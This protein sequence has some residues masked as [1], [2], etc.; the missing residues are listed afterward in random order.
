MTRPSSTKS[1][2]P[3]ITQRGASYRVS[4]M[5]G[6]VRKT[7]TAPTLGDAER[8]RDTLSREIDV[9]HHPEKKAWTLTEGFDH[10]RRAVLGPRSTQPQTVALYEKQMGMVVRLLGGDPALDDMDTRHALDLGALMLDSGWSAGTRKNCVIL[11]LAVMRHAKKMGRMT[12]DLPDFA[13]IR[14]PNKKPKFFSVEQERAIMDYLSHIGDDDLLALVPFLADTGFR[15]G[16][17][18]MPL[19]WNAVDFPGEMVQVWE[20]KGGKHR[21]VPM[22]ARVKL[23]LKERRLRFAQEHGPFGNT[24]YHA[25]QQRW[26]SRLVEMGLVERGNGRHPYSLHTWRHTY[27]TRLVSAGIDLRTVQELAG[28]ADITTTMIYS[29]F[30]PARLRSAAAA[31]EALSGN[32]EGTSMVQGGAKL[33]HMV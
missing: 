22:T 3:G 15:V 25:V 17:E 30:V 4:I 10:Y 7:G 14:I 26:T 19:R 9:I 1:L 27:C 24:T 16:V 32:G 6:G 18:A 13:D 21:A 23:L 2:P 29:H 12:V 33:V 11:L 31:L 8:L 20:G 5:V 28:H